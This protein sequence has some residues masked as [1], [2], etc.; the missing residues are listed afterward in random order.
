LTINMKNFRS[1]VVALA[2]GALVTVLPA[3]ADTISLAITGPGSPIMV[4]GYQWSYTGTTTPSQALVG[5]GI[6]F[7]GGTAAT[8]F[9]S[10][11]SSGNAG[12][13]AMQSQVIDFK[14]TPTINGGAQAAV[15]FEGSIRETTT[16]GLSTYSLVFGNNGTTACTVANCFNTGNGNTINNGQSVIST[17]NGN[18]TLLAVN[19]IDYEVQTTTTLSP[20]KPF[21]FLNGFVGVVNSPEPA[22]Y[23]TTG[24]AAAFLGLFLRRKAKQN[25]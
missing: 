6:S 17:A 25:S 7:S 23:A 4:G 16:N 8:E 2:F 22:T 11:S 1:T 14:V 9:G 19:G 18:Y 24:L 20:T 10:F 21:N 13:T 5:S 15:T 12:A 3:S